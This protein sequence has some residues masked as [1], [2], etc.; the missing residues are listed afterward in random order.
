MKSNKNWGGWVS[1]MSCLVACLLLMTGCP[2]TPTNP[3][4]D[5]GTTTPPDTGTPP[6]D[7]PIQITECKAGTACIQVDGAS[8]RSCEFLL[9]NDSSVTQPQISFDADVMGRFKARGTRIALAWLAQ[10]D[11]AIPA[12]RFVAVVQ[13]K[14]GVKA[15]KLTSSNC[16]DQKGAKV[17]S[18]KVT[19]NIP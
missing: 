1:V 17:A 11:A 6:P 18:P 14:D 4:T 3:P 13:L 10:K 7:K 5:G 15:L 16:Y 19:L 2:S 12:T 9:T 8:L